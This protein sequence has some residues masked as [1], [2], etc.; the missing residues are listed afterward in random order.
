VWTAA[1]SIDAERGADPIFD[2]G[3]VLSATIDS[4]AAINFPDLEAQAGSANVYKG[5]TT[6]TLNGTTITIINSL[7]NGGKSFT[8][9]L[10]ANG[11]I[12][13]KYVSSSSPGNIILAAPNGLQGRLT[14]VSDNDIQIVNHVK[15]K[16]PPDQNPNSTD[17]LGLVAQRSVVVQSAAPNNLQIYAHM[18][19]KTGGFG[20]A[21]YDT[22]SSRGTMTVYGGIANEV[23][24]AV[25]T[26]SGSTGYLK[27]YIFDTRFTNNPPPSYPKV[28]DELEW[29]EWEG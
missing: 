26:G 7:K 3:L 20:V 1:S 13:V 28:I 29:R 11:V 5:N 9:S 6:I 15:Y 18:I 22:G 17:A 23:R 25:G 2:K 16:T 19:C 21:N 12:Y 14:L 10:P 8:T 27:N 24:N 4:M